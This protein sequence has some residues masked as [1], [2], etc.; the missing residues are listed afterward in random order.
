MILAGDVGATN[1]RL[2]LLPDGGAEPRELEIYRSREHP[3]LEEMLRRFGAAH[4]AE[5][6][7]A[8]FG[9]AGPVRDRRTQAVNLA[10]PV[11]AAALADVLGVDSGRVSVINDLEAN[12][13]GLEALKPDDLIPLS[14]GAGTVI[15]VGDRVTR[16]KAGDRVA[17][18]HTGAMCS[19][20]WQW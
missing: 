6:E 2:A 14:D 4:Q 3:S 12:A 1:T 7:A 10:W 16:F 15:G 20:R 13:W 11:D 18:D 17:A 8:T 5:L 9:V 19:S